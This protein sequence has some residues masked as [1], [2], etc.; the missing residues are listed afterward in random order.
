MSKDDFME[1]AYM[2]T[3]AD[4]KYTLFLGIDPSILEQDADIT[5]NDKNQVVLKLSNGLE[6]KTKPVEDDIYDS[7]S[8]RQTLVVFVNNDGDPIANNLLEP[9][10]PTNLK[11]MK[12]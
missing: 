5:L 12:P 11:K 10:K 9:L 4:N 6:L 8:N 7:L 2:R 3:E 1:Y